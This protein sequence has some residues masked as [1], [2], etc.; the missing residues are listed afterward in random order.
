MHECDQAAESGMSGFIYFLRC[1]DF[2][3]VGFSRYPK[4]R[5]T[6]LACANPYPVAVAAVFP[7]TEADERQLH[8]LFAPHR[9]RGEWFSSHPDIEETIKYGPAHFDIPPPHPVAA[10]IDD[11]GG[12]T[13]FAGIIGKGVSTASE[14]KRNA[15]VPV[16]HWPKIIAAA[17]ARGIEGITP[18]KLMR[19]HAGAAA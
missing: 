13:A 17:R 1:N 9:V 3:K 7:G 18:E 11:F 16:A 2:I 6:R 8:R 5:I 19:L 14:M 4:P 10:L 15:S 12:V